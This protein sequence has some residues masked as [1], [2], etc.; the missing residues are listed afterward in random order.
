VYARMRKDTLE[1]YKRVL[2]EFP[3]LDVERIRSSLTPAV[4]TAQVQAWRQAGRIFSVSFED[5]E[6][7][8]TFQFGNGRPKEIVAEVLKLLREVRPSSETEAPY[9]DWSTFCW[10]VSSN[11]WLEGR[12][13][14]EGDQ[15]VN[16]MDSNPTAVVYA[17]AQARNLVSD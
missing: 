17:A 10:F 4:T 9:D 14:L 1:F 16:Q 7:Y 11:S 3:S 2:Q 6:L 5:Q 8:P 12:T 13:P 15:P